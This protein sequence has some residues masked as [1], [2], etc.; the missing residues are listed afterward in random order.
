MAFGCWLFGSL[1]RTFAVLCTQQAAGLGPHLLE[2]LPEAKRAVGNR[3]LGRHRK[4]AP[5]QVEEELPPRLCTLAHPVDEA[6]EFLLTLGRGPDNDQQALR[7]V[8][9]PGLHV[10][11]IDP[12]IDV[13]LGR[14]IALAPARVLVRP[15]VLEPRDGRGREPAGVLAKQRE[16][17]LLEVAGGDTLEVEDRDQHL[18]AL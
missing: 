18:E 11:A 2:R 4:S 6:D 14:E 3:E 1:F 10:D 9:Q 16:E 13:A 17:R 15:G 7:G 5:L 12:E 8:L